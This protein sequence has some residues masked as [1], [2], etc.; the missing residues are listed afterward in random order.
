[1]SFKTEIEAIV[2]DI[3]TPDYTSQAPL[4]LAE[5]VKFVTKYVMINEDMADRLTIAT[6]LDSSPTTL[7]LGSVLKVVNVTRSDAT[8]HREALQVPLAKVPDYTDVNSLY[9]TSKLDP[10]WYVSNNTLNVIPT[11]SDAQPAIVYNITPDTSVGLGDTTI[12]NFPEEL[13]RGVILYACKELLRLMMANVTLPTVPT[14]VTLN[15]TTLADL[16]TAPAYNKPTLTTNYGTLSATD[17][18]S[19]NEVDFGVDDF[20]ADEDPEM[21][22][23]ALGKQQQLLQ[24]YAIDVE[25]EL[26]EYNKELSIYTTDLQQKI[27]AAKMVSESEAQEIQDYMGRVELYANEL[28]S[29]MADYD[30]YSKQLDA[31]TG[32]LSAFL[33][34]YIMQPQTEEKEYETSADDR[35]S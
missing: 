22:Q 27:E 6:T 13:E 4:Y 15:D 14:A 28:N 3:D 7:S 10:K 31:V 12:T 9:Y 33:S 5:G 32:D 34:L 1:M 30:W 23:V 18:T 17:T 8:R 25:N 26:N 29:K 35:V 19:G 24:Q 21:A 16:T 20:I 11:P 2:G